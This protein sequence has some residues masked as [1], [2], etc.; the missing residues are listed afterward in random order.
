MSDER[1]DEIERDNTLEHHGSS[2]AVRGIADLLAEMKRLDQV[3]LDGEIENDC[4]RTQL[5]RVMPIIEAVAQGTAIYS[6]QPLE[7][8]CY[9]CGAW[10]PGD[11]PTPEMDE[12]RHDADCA[13]K[14]ARTV[15][16]QREEADDE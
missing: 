2:N 13:W 15:L 6:D 8:F 5:A 9:F 12:L 14:Q 11:K 4:M 3:I 7:Y 10:S 1:W 16:Q